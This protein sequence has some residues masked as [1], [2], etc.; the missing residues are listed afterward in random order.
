MAQT[1]YE[2]LLTSIDQLYAAALDPDRWQDFLTSLAGQF[3]A[4]NA[5]VCEV[6]YRERSLAYVGL[7]QPDRARIPVQ[8]YETLIADDPRTYA[9]RS[10][11]VQPVHCRMATT[12]ERLHNSRVYREYLKPLGIEYTMVVVLPLRDGTTRDVGLTRGP[13]GRPFDE[14]DRALMSRLVPHV[15]RAF[16]INGALEAKLLAARRQAHLRNVDQRLLELR[17]GLTPAQAQLAALLYDG[18]S[19]KQAATSLGITEGS[20]RQYLKKVFEK[21]GVKRQLDLIRAIE[22]ALARDG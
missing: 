7:P 10:S 9:F 18:V 12:T 17:F 8:R 11:G 5:F 4:K 6:E 14:D 2:T 1:N 21:T 20:A 3:E 19:V 16:T 13:D 22:G 15:E